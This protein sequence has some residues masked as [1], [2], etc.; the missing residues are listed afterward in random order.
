[1][2]TRRT[3]ELAAAL[4]GLGASPSESSLNLYEREPRGKLRLL[5]RFLASFTYECGGRVCIGTLPRGIFAETGT[6][7]EDTEGMVDYARG[8]EG[9]DIGVLIEERDDGVKASLRAKNP[10]VRVDRV[11]AQFGGGG[12]A[13]AAGINQKGVSPDAFRRR[14]VAALETALASVP[15]D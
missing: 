12:H 13:C 8:I 3:F 6:G 9:V 11:A 5:Q 2:T 4:A 1:A 10:A 15:A 14:L 7:P